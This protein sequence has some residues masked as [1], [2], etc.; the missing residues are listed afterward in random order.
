VLRQRSSQLQ[1]HK[2]LR[3]S[4]CWAVFQKLR[5]QAV[6]DWCHNPFCGRTSVM[7]LSPQEHHEAGPKLANIFR[8]G[9]IIATYWCSLIFSRGDDCNLFLYLT[10]K[11]VLENFG[12]SIAGLPS[13]VT[14]LSLHNIHCQHSANI[15]MV[16]RWKISLLESKK[17]L[18]KNLYGKQGR[19]RISAA[20]NQWIVFELLH[21]W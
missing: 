20:D 1:K 14:G 18:V 17:I 11:R 8:G 6:W 13:L 21:A 19:N 7:Q 12:V 15:T 2:F 5:R 10:F 9:K 4:L 3:L 16:E